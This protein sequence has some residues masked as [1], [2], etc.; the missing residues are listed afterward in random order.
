MLK[1]P[2]Q[3]GKFFSTD[4][5]LRHSYILLE[6]GPGFPTNEDALFVTLHFL[7]FRATVGSY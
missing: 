5:I 7:E 1:Q 3:A 2:S 4:A 6:G